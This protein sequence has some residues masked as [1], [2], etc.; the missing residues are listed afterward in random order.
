MLQYGCLGNKC[1]SMCMVEQALQCALVREGRAH[2][3]SFMLSMAS[4]MCG[5]RRLTAGKRARE[6]KQ[7]LMSRMMSALSLH[8]MRRVTVSRSRGTVNCSDGV[9]NMRVQLRAVRRVESSAISARL[10]G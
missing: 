5:G 8:T 3:A 4:T 7:E 2:I 6:S 1:Y 9:S 10:G